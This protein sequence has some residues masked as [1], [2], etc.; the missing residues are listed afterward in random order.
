MMIGEIH[1]VQISPT[2]L[3][4]VI[5]SLHGQQHAQLEF[6]GAHVHT[7]HALYFG[8]LHVQWVPRLVACILISH[9][10]DDAMKLK[11]HYIHA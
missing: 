11:F 2:H 1:C 10:T 3:L 9:V 5:A 4:L 6:Q 7:E 8:V